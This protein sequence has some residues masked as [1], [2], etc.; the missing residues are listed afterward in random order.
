MLGGRCQLRR[1]MASVGTRPNIEG[2]LLQKLHEEGHYEDFLRLVLYVSFL[3]P[4]CVFLRTMISFRILGRD[5]HL[6][7][8]YAEAVD[9][10]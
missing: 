10:R 8:L 5:C 6:F 3:Q 9:L 1:N 4:R 7:A 2:G